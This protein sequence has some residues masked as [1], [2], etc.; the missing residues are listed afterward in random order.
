M[1]CL[2][3]LTSV[4]ATSFEAMIDGDHGYWE[5]RYDAGFVTLSYLVSLVGCVTTLELIHRRTSTHG[6]HNW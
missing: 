4:V 1:H 5:A 2:L 6:A 3:L